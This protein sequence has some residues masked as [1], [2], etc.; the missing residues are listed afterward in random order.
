MNNAELSRH[1]TQLGL[2][3]LNLNKFVYARDQGNRFALKDHH[4]TQ[5]VLCRFRSQA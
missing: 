1:H 2:Y 3:A 4:D 5:D